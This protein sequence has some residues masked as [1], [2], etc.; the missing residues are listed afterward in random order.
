MIV[1]RDPA[2]LARKSYSSRYV[3]D[4]PKVA[5]YARA[6]RLGILQSELRKDMAERLRSD[7]FDS[8]DTSFLN[9][10]SILGLFEPRELLR[11][12]K[13]VRDELLPRVPEIAKQ[14][15]EDADLDISAEDNFDYLRAALNRLEMLFIEDD[16]ATDLLEDIESAIDDGTRAVKKKKDQADEEARMDD[17]WDWENL[18]QPNTSQ[19]TMNFEKG[20]RSVFSDVDE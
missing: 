18:D 6:L 10:D 16:S 17:D 12:R 20:H 15:V 9:D 5:T 11:L 7:L 4:D 14:T 19:P 3:I 13:K 8:C 2:V 1:V